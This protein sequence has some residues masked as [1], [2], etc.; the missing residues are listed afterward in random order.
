MSPGPDI[1]EVPRQPARHDENRVDANVIAFARIAWR[2]PFGRDGNT[3]QAVLV[4]RKAEAFLA[5]S[6]L[7]LDERDDA[8]ATSD[9][10]DLPAG[11]PGAP[12]QDAPAAQP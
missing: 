10:V 2:Q 6:R 12:R 9:Q 11:N 7:H 8:P 5:A 4:E 3:A 1:H